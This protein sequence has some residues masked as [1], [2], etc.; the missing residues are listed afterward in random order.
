[1]INNLQNRLL[2]QL[3]GE[4]RVVTLFTVN[5]FQMKGRITGF[6]GDVVVL[7]ARED[8]KII[9]RHAIST[10]APDRPIGLGGLGGEALP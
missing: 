2:S 3:Q 4:R 8:Q 6:D 7:E 10:I 5:G 1:M 9:F